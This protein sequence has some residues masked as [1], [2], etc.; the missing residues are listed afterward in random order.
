MAGKEQELLNKDSIGMM[1]RGYLTQHYMKKG[2]D[3]VRP[4]E[5]VKPVHQVSP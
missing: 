5:I 4:F 3:P 2:I 1:K